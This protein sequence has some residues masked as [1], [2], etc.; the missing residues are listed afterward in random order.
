MGRTGRRTGAQRNCLFLAT[1][2]EELLTALAIATLWREGEA[3]PVTPPA[4]PAHI[5]AQQVMA[6][7]LQ[8]GG[9]ARPDLDTWLGAV[10]AEVPEGD[11]K[12]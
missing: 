3:D 12:P 10:A 6:L 7:A 2:D 5:Y 4:R 1:D 8:L 11:R 9:I